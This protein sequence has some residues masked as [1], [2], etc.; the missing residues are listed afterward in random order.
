MRDSERLSTLIRI[1]SEQDIHDQQELH[2]AMLREGYNLTQSTISRDLKALKARKIR[3]DCQ[4]QS[5]RKI[6]FIPE[7]TRYIRIRRQ[8]QMRGEELHWYAMTTRK[9]RE[10]QVADQLSAKGIECLVQNVIPKMVFIHCTNA[11]QQTETF[12]DGT[13]GYLINPGNQTPI[14]I[15]DDEIN[16]FRNLLIRNDIVIDF[17]EEIFD[18]DE[19]AQT[20]PLTGVGF[21]M[22]HNSK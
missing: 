8:H 21:L 15:P 10:Q 3:S 5:A 6:Y 11:Q 9:Y 19:S 7:E 1:V 2:D 14:I 12:V 17:D 13:T 20:Y 4:P 16:T 18:Q 22:I